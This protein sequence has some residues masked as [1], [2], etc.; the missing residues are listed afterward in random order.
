MIV[1]ELVRNVEEQIFASKVSAQNFSLNPFL[2]LVN[3]L[4]SF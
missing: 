4:F 2:I 1:G 3:P